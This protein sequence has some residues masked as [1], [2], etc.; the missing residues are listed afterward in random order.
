MVRENWQGG[1]K[2]KKS[3]ILSK[4]LYRWEEARLEQRYRW[5]GEECEE[6]QWQYSGFRKLVK[7]DKTGLYGGCMAVIRAMVRVL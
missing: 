5:F 2:R 1:Q 4:D 7:M 6:G 3:N